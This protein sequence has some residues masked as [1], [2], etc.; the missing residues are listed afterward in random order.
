MNE[1]SITAAGHSLPV[2]FVGS[3]SE[4][5]RIWIVNLLLTLVTLGLYYPFAKVRR[6]RYFHASTEIGGHPLSFHANPW[7]MLRG[8]LLVAALVAVYSLAG[9]I[10]ELGGIVAFVILAGLWPALWHSSLR[11]R[12][13]N[14]GWRGLRFRFLGSR[15]GAYK[16]LLPGLAVAFVALALGRLAQPE[17]GQPPSPLVWV[18]AALP[19]LALLLLPVMLWLLRR[20]QHGHYALAGERT[21]FLVP[22]RA[23]VGLG[24]RGIGMLVGM[25]VLAGVVMAAIVVAA[26]LSGA[27]AAKPGLGMLLLPLPAM[28]LVFIALQAV[29]GSYFTAR[30]QNLVWNG[31]RSQHLRFK[32]RLGFKPL[33]LLT[34]KNWLLMIV[35]LGLYFPF[36]AVASARLRLDAVGV[37]AAVDPDALLGSGQAADEAAAGDAAGDLLG[38]DIGL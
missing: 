36:A 26:K 31:T 34:A 24:L 37:L 25:G 6:L 23:F 18:L 2:R 16:A 5:F 32:S 3:G 7:Q 4:Y 27:G 33:M 38:V 20:Y 29:I 30:L 22:L 14:T 11:F 1:G 35:T 8:Y 9:R 28:L 17:K 19:L 15:G 21:Q 12:L 13:A 10:S